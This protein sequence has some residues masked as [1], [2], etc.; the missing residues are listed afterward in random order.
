MSET[1]TGRPN[2][3]QFLRDAGMGAFGAMALGAMP[4]GCANR[5]E[6]LFANESRPPEEVAT[7]EALWAKVRED[8]TQ[9][10]DFVNLESGYYSP[11]ADPVVDARCRN[12]RALNAEPSFTMRRRYVDGRERIR[13]RLASLAGCPAEEVAITRNTTESLNVVIHGMDLRPD[14]EVIYCDREYPSMKEALAQRRDRYG[15]GLREIEV[16]LV[17]ADPQEVVECYE[18]AIGP[19]TRAILVSHMVYLTGQILPVRE[20]AD[21]A[22]RRGVEV[23]VDGAHSFAHVEYLVPDLGGDYFGASLHKWLGAPLGLGILWMRRDRIERVWPLF[24]DVG[25]PRDDIRKF[26]HTGTQ[27]YSTIQT[28]EDAI[29]FHQAIGA[30][31][32]EARLRYLEDAW[33]N[34]LADRPGI[35]LHTPRD[36]AQSCAIAN[37]S[38]DGMTP[39]ELAD[40]LFDRHRIFTVAVDTGI[41]VA[42]NLFT[43][44]DHLDRFVRAMESLSAG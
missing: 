35:R 25:V 17:P 5:A 39:H 13:E 44:P 3:R 19:K 24:G 11:A 12:L 43:S 41:R 16:P 21:L 10:P 34:R 30:A 27:P 36:A 37:V 23:I 22:R 42:P 26:E 33:V 2:R 6:G 28:L 7:D 29:R 18:R 20:I 15:L 14:D 40:R 31:R 4:I 1:G 8:W 9:S 38:I 32:K